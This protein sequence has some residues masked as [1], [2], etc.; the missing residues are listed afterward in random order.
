MA[1]ALLVDLDDTLIDDRGAMRAAV[2]RFRRKHGLLLHE[3]DAAIVARWDGL[4]RALWRRQALGEFTLQEQRRI[5]LRNCFSLSL[6]DE[7]ADA[8][9][10]DYLAFYEEHWALVPEAAEFLRA[11]AHLPRAIVTNGH[12]AQVRK[13]IDRLGLEPH[14]D[15]IVTPD[16]CGASKPDPRIFQHALQLLGVKAAQALMVGDDHEAD[17]APA[18]ALGMQA[19]HVVPGDVGR[20]IRHAVAAGLI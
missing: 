14:F 10:G 20:S 3:E 1:S 9:F 6:R 15:A 11:T 12:R 2:L 16:D 19:F 18:L 5:R 13:K 4:T 7:E 8:L 17:I